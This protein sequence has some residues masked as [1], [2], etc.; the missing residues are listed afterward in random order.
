MK[1]FLLSFVCSLLLLGAQAIAA[2]EVAG[3]TTVMLDAD[4]ASPGPQALSTDVP[5]DAVAVLFFWHCV[6]DSAEDTGVGVESLSSNFT[7]AI[8]ILHQTRTL[9]GT[10]QTCGGVAVAEVTTTGAGASV[11]PVF[12]EILFAGYS[13]M[14]I[15]F[16]RNV[17][18]PGNF[19][20]WIRDS[21]SD[22]GNDGAA[23]GFNLSTEAGDT[24]LAM[25]ARFDGTITTLTGWTSLAERSDFGSLDIRLMQADTP[26][27]P[28]TAVNHA[29]PFF[30][31]ISGVSLRTPEEPPAAG[32]GSLFLIF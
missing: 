15:A 13:P 10:N 30:A 14:A 16:I 23:V 32:G 27:D 25:A 3:T 31:S 5:A 28:T 19:S 24:V 20:A 22:A 29:N 8:T 4:P 1:S 9:S 7:G 17:S 11:T 26:G 21:N 6:A 12:T 2:P 18:D